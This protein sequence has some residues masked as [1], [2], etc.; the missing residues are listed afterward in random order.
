MDKNRLIL[1]ADG[2]LLHA[3]N[4]KAK[5]KGGDASGPVLD[6]LKVPTAIAKT[7]G[8]SEPPPASDCHWFMVGAQNAG[9]FIETISQSWSVHEFPLR[10]FAQAPGAGDGQV[11]FTPAI[12]WALG[13]VASS[14]VKPT[15]VVVSNDPGVIFPAKFTID[16]G[17]A[18]VILAWPDALG[19]EARYFADWNE[20]RVLPLDPNDVRA[21][22]FRPSF[23]RT[24]LAPGDA[25]ASPRRKS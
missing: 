16:R 4:A 11:R 22:G 19:D 9:K 1:L 7:L 10:A 24:F 23:G 3:R 14:N 8:R 21:P 18:E 6:F 20:V 15:V 5:E 13:N 25:D 2:A 17:T 12:S